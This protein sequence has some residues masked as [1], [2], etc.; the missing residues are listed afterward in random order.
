MYSAVGLICTGTLKDETY[1]QAALDWFPKV[2]IQ[3]M[4]IV[5]LSHHVRA[6]FMLFRQ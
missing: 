6:H 5:L 3:I 2:G 1:T 4:T